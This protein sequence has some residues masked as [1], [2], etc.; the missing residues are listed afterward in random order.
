MRTW[1]DQG[2]LYSAHTLPWSRGSSCGGIS[3]EYGRGECV[4]GIEVGSYEPESAWERWYNLGSTVDYSHITQAKA[5]GQAPIYSKAGSD[6]RLYGSRRYQRE[7]RRSTARVTVL[8]KVTARW[9]R[10]NRAGS[11][12]IFSR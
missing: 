7:P 10:G 8:C 2:H 12:C 5:R 3:L 1:K 9:K 4:I 11:D 6:N